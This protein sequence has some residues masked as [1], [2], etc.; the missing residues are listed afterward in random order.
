MWLAA[1]GVIVILAV[2][3]AAYAAGRSHGKTDQQKQD[4]EIKAEDMARNADIASKPDVDRP[5][6]KLFPR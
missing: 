3:W 5:L 6:S 1:G 2:I 4:A